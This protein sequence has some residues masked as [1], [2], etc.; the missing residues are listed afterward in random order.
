MMQIGCSDR[1]GYRTYGGALFACLVQQTQTCWASRDVVKLSAVGMS[2]E[3]VLYLVINLIWY[4]QPRHFLHQRIVS[5]SIQKSREKIGTYG[6]VD[7][8]KQT[9]KKGNQRR[10]RPSRPEGELL[11][12]TKTCWWLDN[13]SFGVAFIRASLTVRQT[14][15]VAIFKQANGGHR[16]SSNYCDTINMSFN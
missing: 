1:I 13:V 5:Y 14:S 10:G 9:V 12:E 6:L 11:G 8:S 4:W 2:M 16:T 7:S 3:K 15:G